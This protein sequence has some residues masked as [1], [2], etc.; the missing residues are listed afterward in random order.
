[1][2]FRS[3]ARQRRAGRAD[4][5]ERFAGLVV[6]HH[7]GAVFDLVAAQFGCSRPT[8]FLLSVGFPQA[9]RGAEPSGE[10]AGRVAPLY[11]TSPRP[12]PE[13]RSQAILVPAPMQGSSRPGTPSVTE[14][15]VSLSDTPVFSA[16]IDGDK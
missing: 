7:D 16:E 12:T 15:A 8:P 9:G 3:R 14:L 5:G 2:L 10:P 1:V 6:E 11:W 4:P 13:Q